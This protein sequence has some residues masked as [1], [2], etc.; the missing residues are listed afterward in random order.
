MRAQ[1]SGGSFLS[2]SHPRGIKV[3]TDTD[4]V[5]HIRRRVLQKLVDQHPG[6]ERLLALAK[7][8]GVTPLKFKSRDNEGFSIPCGLCVQARDEVAGVGYL[9][10]GNRALNQEVTTSYH[11]PNPECIGC[12]TCLYL[13]PTEAMGRSYERVRGGGIFANGAGEP[14]I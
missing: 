5:Q 7:T 4:Y 9:S 10:F 14:A 8:Y 6:S 1:N 3:A 11:E 2:L 13:C 12:W